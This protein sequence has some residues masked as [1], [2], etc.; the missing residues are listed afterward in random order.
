MG[1]DALYC[2]TGASSLSSEL[3]VRIPATLGGSNE[4]GPAAASGVGTDKTRTGS[5]RAG[6]PPTLDG[7]RPRTEVEAGSEAWRQICRETAREP[8]P[9]PDGPSTD[10]RLA[11]L[12]DLR[13]ER[14]RG[15][16]IGYDR[17][18][19]GAV[20]TVA[21]TIPVRG[22]RLGDPEQR[23]VGGVAHHVDRVVPPGVEERRGAD[24]LA[25]GAERA[26]AGLPDNPIGVMQ[27]PLHRRQRHQR[28]EPPRHREALQTF[29]P[30]V[31]RKP[32]ERHHRQRPRVCVGGEGEPHERLDDSKVAL[33]LGQVQDRPQ[34]V[35]ARDGSLHRDEA[36]HRHLHP[37][38]VGQQGEEQVLVR[39]R[40]ALHP[41]IVEGL[42]GG[43]GGHVR[44]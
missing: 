2:R 20:V 21:L 25:H 8:L 27:A 1:G 31:E 36:L 14:K 11:K 18:R 3:D 16:Q 35:L 12:A 40:A 34:P 4:N 41:E 22:A 26:G 15:V 5:R 43:G 28:V 32:A 37:S 33:R 19:L 9:L 7:S 23:L 39:Q 44:P 38:H 13:L 42:E 10:C 24:A 6:R 29:P 17:V 30:L